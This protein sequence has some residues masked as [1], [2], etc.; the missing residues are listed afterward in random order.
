[1]TT[2]TVRRPHGSPSQATTPCSG[3]RQR[4]RRRGLRAGL[5]AALVAVGAVAIAPSAGAESDQS[6]NNNRSGVEQAENEG[7]PRRPRLT[8][9]QRACIEQ[10]GVDLPERPARDA[11]DDD[12]ANGEEQ[13]RNANREKRDDDADQQ[14]QDDDA[15]GENEQP[16]E[17]RGP[18]EAQ[19]A[20]F[21]AA[22]EAC[23]IELPERPSE[24]DPQRPDDA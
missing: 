6:S 17:R 11:S 16:R 8:D 1:M 5:A 18:T 13:N 24:D 3:G 19:R 22:A 9:E 20:E 21:E 14:S 4:R 7:R 23:G 12:Q 10:Q 2:T 15:R